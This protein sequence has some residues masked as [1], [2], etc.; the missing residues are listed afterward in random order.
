MAQI[1]SEG[2]DLPDSVP[3]MI[4]FP[5]DPEYKGRIIGPQGSNIKKLIR[6]FQLVSLNVTDDEHVEISVVKGKEHELSVVK[7]VILDSCRPN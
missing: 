3:R 1:H 6:E 2:V 4:R 5:I 7:Q